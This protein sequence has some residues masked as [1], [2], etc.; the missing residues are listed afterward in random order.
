MLPREQCVIE[1]SRGL[2]GHLLNT[3]GILI[4]TESRQLRVH[5]LQ[6]FDSVR[7][8]VNWQTFK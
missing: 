3:G 1:L 5:W 2:V 8:Y 7:Q 6:N 4:T